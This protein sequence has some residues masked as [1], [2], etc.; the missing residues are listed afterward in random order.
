ML[1]MNGHD[2]HQSLKS[3]IVAR[4]QSRLAPVLLARLQWSKEDIG[5]SLHVSPNTFSSYG[6]QSTDFLGMMGFQRSRCQFTSGECYWRWV[7]EGFDL[8]KFAQAFGQ[9]YGQLTEAEKRLEACGFFID[10]SEGWGFFLGG[11]AR[12]RR[13]DFGMSGDGHT[14]LKVQAMKQSEDANFQFR[15]TWLEADHSKGWITHYRPKHPPLSSELESV[16]AFLRLNRFAQCPEYDF[17]ECH[18]RSVAFEQ[19][20]DS[21][22]D[23]N[24]EFAHRCFDAH[25]G[26]FSLG[27]EQLL[28]ANAS[29][30]QVGLKFLPFATPSARLATDIERHTSRPGPPPVKRQDAPAAF[31]V[32]ISFA[33]TERKFAQELATMVKD[34]GF[35]VFYDDFYP[36]YLWGKNFTDTFDEIFRKRARYCVIFVSKEY[37]ERM[38]TNHERQSAQ[39]RALQEKG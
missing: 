35:S 9:A 39:A 24:V 2:P 32:A 4:A 34:S 25:A 6:V 5:F 15:F 28:A 22:F 26:N 27:I 10:Q 11:H 31:D 16:F 8:E 21:H 20:G 1:R 7:Q 30:E 13:R 14:G 38:W 18:W 29:I 3:E 12:S 17:E 33:G 23:S 37:A 36:E 19:R